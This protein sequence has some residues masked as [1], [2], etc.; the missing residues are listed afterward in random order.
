LV[1][2]YINFIIESKNKSRFGYKLY[3]SE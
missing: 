1:G 2:F 3:S